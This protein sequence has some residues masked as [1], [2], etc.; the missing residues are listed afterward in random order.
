MHANVIRKATIMRSSPPGRAVTGAHSVDDAVQDEGVVRQL[1]PTRPK[2]FTKTSVLLKAA[3]TVVSALMV[4]L[5][6][7]GTS[8]ADS[9]DLQRTN[10][11]QGDA[12]AVLSAFGSGGWA[13][14]LRGTT[15]VAAPADSPQAPKVQIRPFTPFNGRHYCQLDWHTILLADIEGGGKSYTEAAATTIING[16][17]VQLTLDGSDVPLTRIPVARFLNPE[18]FGFEKAWYSQW[19]K[20]LAPHE[21]TVGSHS[22]HGRVTNASGTVLFE[23]TITFVIDAAGTGTCTA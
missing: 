18:P 17:K 3:A 6:F 15:V 23:N 9:N 11:T 7:A 10:A 20:V 8:R 4:L 14:L 2:G 16:L 22:L 1:H 12:E 13:A 19:G 5:A 21:L